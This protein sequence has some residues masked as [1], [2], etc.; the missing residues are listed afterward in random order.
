MDGD[1][2]LLELLVKQRLDEARAHSARHALLASGEPGRLRS[3][4]ALGLIRAGR[5]L[6]RRRALGGRGARLPRPSLT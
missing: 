4:L 5:W 3:A 6:G 2:Y 1:T